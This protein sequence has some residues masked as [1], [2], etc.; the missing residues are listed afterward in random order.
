MIVLHFNDSVTLS[1]VQKERKGKIIKERKERRREEKEN[2]RQG[3][4]G[5]GLGRSG[6]K[7]EK[8]RKKERMEFQNNHFN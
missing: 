5:K 6:K 3:R 4:E 1:N 2:K 7:E 8:E